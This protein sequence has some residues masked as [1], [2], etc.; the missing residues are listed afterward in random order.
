[1][2]VT[3]ERITDWSLALDAARQTMHKGAI[4]KEPSS[5]WKK[6][7]IYA[8]HSPLRLV[9]YK[10]TIKDIP[11]WVSVHFVRHH[12]GIE[13]FVS[14]QRTDRTGIDR[15]KLPQDAPVDMMFVANAQAMINISRFRLCRQASKETREIWQE[16]INQLRSVDKE[17]A[18]ACVPN[19]IYRGFCPE[20]QPC[21]FSTSR[22]Y[23]DLKRNYYGNKK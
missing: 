14:S 21:G 5:E 8:E 17:L 16:V 2:E 6:K 19:C 3:V 7:L 9:E 1:M 20:M 11:S 15:T 18:D 4:N 23:E 22:L 13:K 12:I 10:V